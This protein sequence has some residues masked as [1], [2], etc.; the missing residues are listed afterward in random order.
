MRN[1]LNSRAPKGTPAMAGMLLCVVAC[2]PLVGCL[3]PQDEQVISQLPRKRNSPLKVVPLRP[4]LRTTFYSSNACPSRNP[5]FEVAVE[6]PDVADTLRSLWFIDLTSNANPVPY[7][8]TPR[9]S[10]N[11]VSRTVAAP[12]S[13]SFTNALSNLSSETHLLTVY[14]SDSE[15]DEVTNGNVT[16]SRPPAGFL[17]DG[18]PLLDTPSI[19]SY[20]WVLDVEACP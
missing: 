10:N 2:A 18:G 17:S 7:A 11:S 5:S 16:A 12:T 8:T 1:D 15:F 3:L 6:D 14:V 20:T 19:D 4:P 9:L 13:L